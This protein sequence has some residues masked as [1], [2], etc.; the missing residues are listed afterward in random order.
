MAGTVGVD[1]TSSREFVTTTASALTDR[2]RRAHATATQAQPSGARGRGVRASKDDP[3]SVAIGAGGASGRQCDITPITM[4][5]RLSGA[6]EKPGIDSET[7]A[8]KG[9]TPHAVSVCDPLV[10]HPPH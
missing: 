6:T 7:G 5:A 2:G 8:V 9:L 3:R 1:E 10:L 4:S